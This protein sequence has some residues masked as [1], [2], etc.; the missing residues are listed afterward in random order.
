[1]NILIGRKENQADR[2]F[3][4]IESIASD[5]VDSSTALDPWKQLGHKILSLGTRKFTSWER[6]LGWKLDPQGR[7]G[8]I[9]FHYRMAVESELKGEGRRADFFW[10]EIYSEVKRDHFKADQR[11]LFPERMSN[12]KHSKP[13]QLH[14]NFIKEVL[15]DTHCALYNGRVRQA[16]TLSPTDRAFAH[17]DYIEHLLALDLVELSE[18]ASFILLAWP[19]RARIS[20]FRDEEK[21]EDAIQICTRILQ[22]FPA[23]L[24]FQNEL[25]DLHT[26][27]IVKKLG[28]GTSEG[29]SKSDAKLLKKG[30][31]KLEALRKEYLHNASVYRTMGHLL[32]LYAIKLANSNSLSEALVQNQRAITFNPYLDAAREAKEKLTVMMTTLR[33][34]V[35]V[36]DAK[37]AARPNTELTPEGYQMKNDAAR[38]FQPM[39]DY[40]QSSEAKEVPRLLY[41]AEGRALW[42]NIGLPEPT[43]R[44]NERSVSLMEGL[45]QVINGQPEDS[46]QLLRDW[47]KVA[48]SNSDLAEL[49]NV[50]VLAFLN[51][52]L[53]PDENPESDGQVSSELPSYVPV[54]ECPPAARRGREEPLSY[55]FFSRRGI[56]VK[57]QMATTLILLVVALVLGVRESL[58]RTTRNEAYRQII[59]S[60]ADGDNHAVV[61]AAEAFLSASL[62]GVGDAREQEVQILYSE[63]LVRWFVSEGDE[64]DTHTQRHLERFQDLASDWNYQGDDYEK[65]T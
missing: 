19:A 63:A 35:S 55:W 59:D 22:R 42:E 48:E 14:E 40:L 43:D 34:Q 16:D 13:D 18:D 20:S 61:E 1:M 27:N 5:T 49:D 56:R 26:T 62:V 17:A 10:Q 2:L 60:A 12:Y 24:E 8:R 64:L 46:A 38:G 23:S 7:T 4:A 37:L 30:L 52:Q 45:T 29:E 32:H 47:K 6:L 21:W 33:T 15:I 65:G 11:A 58:N 57:L 9:L 3:P 31:E 28:N 25:V 54:L 41:W 36:L 44:W 53:W 39:N 51:R 50:P